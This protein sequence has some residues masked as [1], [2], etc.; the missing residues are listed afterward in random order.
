LA[1]VLKEVGKASGALQDVDA[2]ALAVKANVSVRYASAVIEAMKQGKLPMGRDNPDRAA[3]QIRRAV[4]TM[5]TEAADRVGFLTLTFPDHP[6]DAEA[7]ERWKRFK[8][9]LQKHARKGIRIAEWTAA[10]VMHFH[11]VLLMEKPIRDGYDREAVKAGDYRAVNPNLRGYW[12]WLRE[13][14]PAYGF[15]WHQLEPVFFPE[16][17]AVYLSKALATGDVEA[18]H[19]DVRLLDVWGMD[20]LQA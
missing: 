16:G 13:V 12:R 6:T 20:D 2:A 18:R 10:G 5:A 15:G 7:V 4:S 14:L 17:L 3:D 8:A 11:V 9:E 1:R 19:P